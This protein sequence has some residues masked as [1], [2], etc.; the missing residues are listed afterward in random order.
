MCDGAAT[1]FGQEERKKDDQI[2]VA[3]SSTLYVSH[4]GIMKYL[5]AFCF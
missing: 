2:P 1:S 5:N 4:Y 3:G